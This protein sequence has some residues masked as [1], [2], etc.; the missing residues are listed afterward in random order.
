MSPDQLDEV[1]DL[2]FA[3]MV[4]HIRDEASAIRNASR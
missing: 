1:D 3:A 4:Q 2:V